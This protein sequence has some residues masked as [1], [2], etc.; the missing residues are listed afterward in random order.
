MGEYIKHK[1]KDVKIGTC[2]TLYYVSYK[3]YME[4]MNAGHLQK[5]D[6]NS[7]PSVYAQTDLGFMFRF[8]FPDEDK[9]PFGKIIEP[10]DRGLTVILPKEMEYGTGEKGYVE[11]GIRFQ[12]P[13]Y[14]ESDGTLCLAVVYENTETKELFRIEDDENIRQL[15]AQMVYRNIL[16]ESNPNK[17]N[18]YRSSI[19]RILEGYGMDAI[20]EYRKIFVQAGKYNRRSQSKQTRKGKGL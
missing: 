8:P 4:A 3:K 14:R 13:V 15:T 11:I 16:N 10:Y 6:G 5:S 12:K 9:L 20:A 1:G 19:L 17:R 18:L 2:E 7:N